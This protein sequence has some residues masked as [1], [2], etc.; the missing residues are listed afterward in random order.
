MKPLRIY[1]FFYVIETFA[2]REFSS[3][4]L[5]SFFL[6]GYINKC[7]FIIDKVLKIVCLKY[8][9]VFFRELRQL[10]FMF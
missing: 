1:F 3:K 8:S 2:Y 9:T 6:F 7:I 5:K 4:I 10:I